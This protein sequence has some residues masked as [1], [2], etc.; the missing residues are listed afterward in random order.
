VS[1][2]PRFSLQV[3]NGGGFAL[4]SAWE[5]LRLTGWPRGRWVN[6]FTGETLDVNGDYVPLAR[7]LATFPVG[8]F[9]ED[10]GRPAP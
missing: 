2:V 7:V 3:T 10:D 8:L 6:V 9:F 1:V 4:G 5:D